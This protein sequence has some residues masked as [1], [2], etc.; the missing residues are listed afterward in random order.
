MEENK[1]LEAEVYTL[2]DEDGN[3]LEFE[4]IASAVLNGKTYFAMV[5]M[6]EQPEEEDVCEYVILCAEK[7]EDGEDILVTVDDDDEFDDIAE[8]FDDMLSDEAD[9]DVNPSEEKKK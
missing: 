2:T 6:D 8:Y 5:P 3:E 9:Y 1:D 4:V 7:D